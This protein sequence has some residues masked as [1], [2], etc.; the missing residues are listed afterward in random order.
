MKLNFNKRDPVRQDT[1]LGPPKTRRRNKT[2]A[3]AITLALLAASAVPASGWAATLSGVKFIDSE[4]N[5]TQGQFDSG[6]DELLPNE[7]IYLKSESAPPFKR[8]SGR[9]TDDEGKYVFDGLAPGTYRVWQKVNPRS[10]ELTTYENAHVVTI[11]SDDEVISSGVDFPIQ[12]I[13]EDEQSTI[14]DTIEIVEGTESGQGVCDNATSITT[15]VGVTSEDVV[16]IEAGVDI[17][18]LAGEIQI[19]ALCNYGTLRSE[20]GEDLIINAKELIAN[21]GSIIG[22]SGKGSS[23]YLPNEITPPSH[24]SGNDIT[25]ERNNGERGSN[26]ILSVSNDS[27]GCNISTPAHGIFYNAETGV[28]QAGQGGSGYLKG[29][30]GGV[31]S[32]QCAKTI[33][34]AGKIIAGKGGE[35]NAHQPSWDVW[36]GTLSNWDNSAPLP[37]SFAN[38]SPY[39][40]NVPVAG[41][42]GGESYIT[43]DTESF[44]GTDTFIATPTSQT[45]SGEGGQAGVWCRSNP[46]QAGSCWLEDWNNDD[47]RWPTGNCHCEGVEVAESTQGEGGSLEISSNNLT[48]QGQAISGSSLYFEPEMILSGPDMHIEAKKDVVIFGGDDWKLNLSNLSN[49]AIVAGR[50]I[51]LA[52][53]DGGKIDL[54]GNASKVFKAA[55]KVKIHADTVLLDD[56]VQLDNLIEADEIVVRPSQILYNV[57]LTGQQQIKGVPGTTLPVA[58]TISNSGPTTDSYTLNVSDSAGWKLSSLPSSVT[59]DGLGL[60]KLVLNVTLPSKVGIRDV[61]TVTAT[62]QTVPSV[63]A[64]MEIIVNTSCRIWAVH[65]EEQNDSQ[66]FE[67]RSTDLG[68]FDVINRGILREGY[69]LESLD[70]HPLTGELYMA[71]SSDATNLPGYLYKTDPKNWADL[72]SIGNIGFTMVDSLSFD[73]EGI[74]WGWQRGQGLLQIDP[75]T[76]IGNLVVPYTEDVEDISWTPSG[77]L[78]YAV[79]HRELLVWDGSTLTT[80]CTLPRETEGIEAISEK[81][82]MFGTHGG[83]KNVFVIDVENG[84]QEINSIPTP[85]DDIEGI[86][87]SSSTCPIQ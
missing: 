77:N 46:I 50:D 48:I 85:Y 27:G 4:N 58:L 36:G 9:L 23:D 55:G 71:S 5:G 34:Q 65:D 73:P 29:G 84:C 37:N 76:G 70:I 80:A 42:S 82:L 52:V 40:A 60:K 62:S 17:T 39:Y 43:T 38:N 3:R 6:I 22:E 10:D 81:M 15:F 1:N 31:A 56:G 47:P 18:V 78:L 8:P 14:D 74:L 51:V 45:I 26:V 87:W 79:Q 24:T 57:T 16:K 12:G 83:D 32:V 2:L 66:L 67:I 11:S 68:I 44:T 13:T 49:D 20:P 33:I 28:I 21:Y 61:I 72:V 7:I 35:A 30:N 86:A 63:V 75:V 54:S 25:R 59:L 53:G 19:E 69:D 64:V 41:G